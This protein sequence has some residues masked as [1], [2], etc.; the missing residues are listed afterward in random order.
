MTENG[1]RHLVD[2][3]DPEG[4]VRRMRIPG[5]GRPEHSLDGRWQGR[6]GIV[7]HRDMQANDDW[8]RGHEV[9]ICEPCEFP[10]PGFGDC[11]LTTNI[12]DVRALDAEEV[13]PL[14]TVAYGPVACVT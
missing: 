10:G 4:G 2:L 14:G 3:R 9:V 1:T 12:V 6:V 8:D 7:H 5:D 13:P 11:H